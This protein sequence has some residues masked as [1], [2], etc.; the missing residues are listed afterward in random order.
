ML[1]VVVTFVGCSGSN[2]GSGSGS[3]FAWLA[4][5]LLRGFGNG[6]LVVNG[7]EW[8]NLGDWFFSFI[9]TKHSILVV[10]L[11]CKSETGIVH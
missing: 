3:S 6:N 2:S 7:V 8:V 11:L 9:K 4:T 10:Y 1:L 5:A